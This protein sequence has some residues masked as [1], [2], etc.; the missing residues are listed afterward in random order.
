MF[1]QM[2]CGNTDAELRHNG[3]NTGIDAIEERAQYNREI[4]ERVDS[5]LCGDDPERLMHIVS[6]DERI[7]DSFLMLSDMSTSDSDD[8]LARAAR[9]LL[10]VMEEELRE[11]V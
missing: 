8:R 11:W 2:P 6:N 10:R 9:K 4:K 1:N 5:L 3:W 7:L